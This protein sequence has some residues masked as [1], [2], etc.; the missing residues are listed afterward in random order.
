M[1]KCVICDELAIH[2]CQHK[3]SYVIRYYCKKHKPDS[4]SNEVCK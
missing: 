1:N 2:K 4:D 3:K